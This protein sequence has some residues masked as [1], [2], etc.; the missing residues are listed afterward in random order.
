[1]LKQAGP[2]CPTTTPTIRPPSPARCN[3]GKR[4][5]AAAGP[6]ATGQPRRRQDRARAG[7]SSATDSTGPTA[8]RASGRPRP[9]WS[10]AKIRDLLGWN[11]SA[12]RSSL[13]PPS[14][15]PGGAFRPK[16][17][18]AWGYGVFSG[19]ARYR[20]ARLR[21]RPR[22]GWPGAANGRTADR[23][24]VEQAEVRFAVD[25]INGRPRAVLDW[26][27]AAARFASL[28]TVAVLQTKAVSDGT[29]NTAL[30]PTAGDNSIG[31]STATATRELPQRLPIPAVDNPN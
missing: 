6:A 23:S 8:G 20:P 17:G 11:G 5:P 30:L 28:Q 19:N 29:E 2:R 15:L 25:E 31:L 13:I 9:G 1:M 16:R 27:S 14:G 21:R 18:S 12:G 4:R 26:D 7:R 3:G 24:T 10:A 22:G